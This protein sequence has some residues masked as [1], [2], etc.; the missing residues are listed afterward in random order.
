MVLENLLYTE[1]HE[2]V[3]VE[4]EMAYFGITDYAQHELGDIVYFEFPEIGD[5]ITA[6]E[7]FGSVEAVKAVEDMFAPVSGEVI[8]INEAL[9]DKPEL[10]NQSPFEEGWII[11][12]KLSDKSELEKLLDAKSYE[13]LIGE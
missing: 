9:E 7:T 6:G 5:E 10:A 13:K 3:K 4:G 2:W 11:K 12:I 8:E 1:N